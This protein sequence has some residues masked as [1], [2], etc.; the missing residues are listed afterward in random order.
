MK[1]ITKTERTKL[2]L[3]AAKMIL[4]D[5]RITITSGED[6]EKCFP[7]I[8]LFRRNQCLTLE[9]KSIGFLFCHEIA[10]TANK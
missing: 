5:E 1:K 4:D 9:E 10:K 2:Y 6:M 8:F 3:R 7:E